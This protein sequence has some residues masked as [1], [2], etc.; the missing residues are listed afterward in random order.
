MVYKNTERGHL[1]E[2]PQVAFLQ[3]GKA[4]F[5]FFLFIPKNGMLLARYFTHNYEISI[6]SANLCIGKFDSKPTEIHKL[7]E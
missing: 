3:N 5:L 2:K 4:N 1:D 7:D 6:D